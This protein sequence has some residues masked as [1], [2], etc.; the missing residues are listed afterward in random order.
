MKNKKEGRRVEKETN[1]EII[2]SVNLLE[3]DHDGEGLIRH[4]YRLHVY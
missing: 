2:K 3:D 4:A 1:V